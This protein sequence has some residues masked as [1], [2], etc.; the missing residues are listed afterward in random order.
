MGAATADFIAAIL[1]ERPVAISA[2]DGAAAVRIAQAI[3][4]ATRA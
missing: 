4:Q 1:G 3:D 2:A